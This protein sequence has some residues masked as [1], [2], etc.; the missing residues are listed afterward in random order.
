MYEVWFFFPQVASL[1]LYTTAVY[2]H[3]N[4]P[5]RDDNRYQKGKACPLPVLTHYAVQGIKKLRALHVDS[6][7]DNQ[8]NLSSEQIAGTLQVENKASEVSSCQLLK[9]RVQTQGWTMEGREKSLMTHS[10]PL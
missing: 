2:Q 10:D 4:E 5:L 9:K 1:R 7:H 8:V 3:M 6:Y